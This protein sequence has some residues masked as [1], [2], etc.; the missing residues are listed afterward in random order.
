MT[1][2]HESTSHKLKITLQLYYMWHEPVSKRIHTC[3]FT[4]RY[5]YMRWRLKVD[6]APEKFKT[7]HNQKALHEIAIVREENVQYYLTGQNETQKFEGTRWTWMSTHSVSPLINF[8]VNYSYF[9]Y[10]LIKKNSNQEFVNVL[11]AIRSQ[12]IFFKDKMSLTLINIQE[13]QILRKNKTGSDKQHR[14]FSHRKSVS[15]Q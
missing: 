9:C 11:L 12:M 15:W 6:T 1:Q 5:I 7:L 13:L 8:P 10:P 3:I 2:K 14:S 4:N